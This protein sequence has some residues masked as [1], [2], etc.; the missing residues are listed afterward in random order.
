MAGLGEL[1]RV[2]DMN[3]LK[4]FAADDGGGKRVE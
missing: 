3:L 4:F 2:W 1:G